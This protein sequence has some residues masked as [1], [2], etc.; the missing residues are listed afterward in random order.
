MPCIY[1]QSDTTGVA[2][3][4]APA[5]GPVI[6]AVIESSGLYRYFLIFSLLA[7]RPY[8]S[9]PHKQFRNY[10]M[11]VMDIFERAGNVGG[12]QNRAYKINNFIKKIK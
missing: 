9:L 12:W 2:D 4:G 11:D 5:R 6:V 8:V 10:A 3:V 1:Q 7:K